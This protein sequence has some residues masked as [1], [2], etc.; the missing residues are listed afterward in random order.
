MARCTQNDSLTF[1]Q[2]T[3]RFRACHRFAAVDVRG[4]VVAGDRAAA[5]PVQDVWVFE[6]SFHK[7]PQARWRLAGRLGGIP[8]VR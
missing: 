3:V 4:Q 5:I 8:P 7:T 6:H 2:L 1:A